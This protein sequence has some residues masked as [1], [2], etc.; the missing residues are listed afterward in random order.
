MEA[1][2]HFTQR[3]YKQASAFYTQ[4]ITECGHDIPNNLKRVLYANRAQ[5]H[6]LLSKY[7]RPLGMESSGVVHF[8]VAENYG[9]CV[10]DCAE[11]LSVPFELGHEKDEQDP[12]DAKVEYHK[13]TSKAYFRSA[14][15]LFALDKWK[16]CLDALERLA[17]HSPPLD[18]AA[19]QLLDQVKERLAQQEAYLHKKAQREQ[20]QAQKDQTLVA[21]LKVR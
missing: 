1:N 16:Q 8:L 17:L 18:T 13:T 10:R 4:A 2:D 6:L 14:K 11:V 7:S 9:S 21:E 15:A 5:C 3:N 12:A 19:N 20:E